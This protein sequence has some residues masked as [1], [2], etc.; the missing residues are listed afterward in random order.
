VAPP[1]H[2]KNIFSAFN[3]VLKNITGPNGITYKSTPS[4]LIVQPTDTRTYN[5]IIDNLHETNVTF[6]SST[7]PPPS[8]RTFRVIIKNLH[9]STL[10]T[11]IT[12]ALAELGHSVKNIYNAKNRNNCPLLLFFVDI[13]QQ[14]NNNVIHDI[15]SLL[16]TNTQ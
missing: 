13:R 9:N 10:H 16:N 8:H 2:I 1:I 12:S 7:P 5:A 14:D 4:Y 11:D 3:T 6:R 15:T